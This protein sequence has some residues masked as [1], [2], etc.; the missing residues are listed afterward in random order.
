MSSEINKIFNVEKKIVVLTGG[1][2]ILGSVFANALADAGAK[3]A[4]LEIREG[5]LSH[6]NI[7]VYKTD[8]TKR[9]SLEEA[10]ANI[11]KDFGIPN[12]LINC[13]A[14]D[15]PP[16]YDSKG[17]GLLETDEAEKLY[18]KVM[19]VNV[20]GLLLCSQVFGKAMSENRDGSIINISSI[21]G[22]ISPDQRIYPMKD[23]RKFIKPIAYSVSKSAL[24]NLTRYLAT[25]WAK[26]NVRVNTLTF[27]GV[28]NEQDPTF[29]ANYSSKVPLGRMANKEDYVGAIFFLASDAS[30]YMTGSNLV[31]D[32][33]YTAL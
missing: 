9:A 10:L 6:K 33:G 7:R 13:A 23:G 19:E 5:S 15:F 24:F 31:I 11:K 32:G 8:I 29:V 1:L 3:V 28:F 14:I 2:G 22:M 18:D 25:Y 27:G 17:R 20:K 30:S 12:V 21:Y 26:D 4:I 16:D